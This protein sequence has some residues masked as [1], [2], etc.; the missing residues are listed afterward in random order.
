MLWL[1]DRA[2]T[3]LLSG[4]I[5]PSNTSLKILHNQLKALC[6][7]KCSSEKFPFTL[8][9]KFIHRHSSSQVLALRSADYR[10]LD[11]SLQIIVHVK[12]QLVIKL[13]ITSR[14]LS[15]KSV[16]RACVALLFPELLRGRLG[17]LQVLRG[18][19]SAFRTT[20]VLFF[21]MQC[22]HLLYRS[23]PALIPQLP[24]DL[25][26]LRQTNWHPRFSEFS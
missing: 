5:P 24:L 22:S 18:F 7:F 9:Q 12:N 1:T 20:C 15:F 26:I 2:V 23:P 19:A 14:H 16:Y 4:S 10:N 6:L 8:H 3:S 25:W 11:T 21:K 13:P 17:T